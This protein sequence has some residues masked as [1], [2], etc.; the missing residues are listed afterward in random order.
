MQNGEKWAI[1]RSDGELLQSFVIDPAQ[2]SVGWFRPNAPGKTREGQ[3][4]PLT[5]QQI[6]KAQSLM[7]AL[8]ALLPKEFSDA[9]VASFEVPAAE[10]TE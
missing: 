1:R 4:G 9:E 6:S 5:F 7:A 10:I 3:K 2:I 8:F